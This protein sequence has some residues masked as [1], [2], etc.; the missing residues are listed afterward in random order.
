MIVEIGNRTLIRDDSGIWPGKESIALSSPGDV[1][2]KEFMIKENPLQYKEIQLFFSYQGIKAGSLVF[3]INGKIK[4][5]SF[6]ASTDLLNT[7][8]ISLPISCFNQGL[9]TIIIE[10][11]DIKILI[12]IDSSYTFGRS[13]LSKNGKWEKLKKGEFMIWLNLIKDNEPIQR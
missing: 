9:N 3:D 11:Q 5:S 13:Y 2:K 1:I 4:G 6:L 10:A 8:S 7:G 12:P